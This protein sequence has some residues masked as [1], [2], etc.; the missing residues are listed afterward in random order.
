MNVCAVV[1]PGA[2][3]SNAGEAEPLV[4]LMLRVAPER[5]GADTGDTKM[6]GEVALTDRVVGAPVMLNDDCA[7]TLMLLFETAE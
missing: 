2:K 5:N 7:C 1:L 3:L 6:D 4:Q